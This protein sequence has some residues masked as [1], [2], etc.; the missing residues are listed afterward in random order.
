MDNIVDSLNKA[1]EKFVIASADVLESKESAGGLKA[2][3]TDA[4]LENFKEKWE[5]FRVACDQAEEFV[6]SVK[7]RIGSE[8]LVD[9]ATGLTTTTT[10]GGGSNSGQSVGAA[11][12]LPPISAVRLEQ[13]SRA[14]RWLVLE[15]QRGSGGAA[16]GSVHS[17]RYM[18]FNDPMLLLSSRIGQIGDLG[19]DLLWRFLHIVVSLFHIVSGIFE[20]IQSY[21]I[22]LGLIQKYSSIDIEK[23]MCLAVVV[24]IEVA[25][26]VAKVVELL[27][28]LKTIGVKQVGLFDSQGLLKKSKD[29]ILEMVPG[30]MLLQSSFLSSDNKEA[31]VKAANILLQRHLKASHPEKDEGDNVFTESHLNEALRV[32]GENVHVPDLMLVYGPV[33]S[34]LG[35]PAWRLRY[36]EIVHMGSLK[37]MRYGSLLKAIHKFTGVRQ[38]YGKSFLF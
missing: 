24:D 34:H 27:Q 15:L 29:M 3:L 38:N 30:S 18:D 28:W 25:R 6:E 7:Q 2:S 32:V 17:P 11:T 4:A 12:S 14:V 10:G 21:A 13:M 35:F 23:L 5:L 16:A 33:R 26:D 36:T 19:L 9:E 31:V 1:Y 22:S 37:Y 8:C 20:A